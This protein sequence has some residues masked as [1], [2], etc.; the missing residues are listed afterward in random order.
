MPPIWRKFAAL[1]TVAMFMLLSACAAEDRRLVRDEDTCRSM[2][3]AQDTPA[4]SQCLADLNDRSCAS[5][6]KKGHI[7]DLSCTKR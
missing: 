7:G 3:H 4:F 6:E 2:G 1:I 5:S